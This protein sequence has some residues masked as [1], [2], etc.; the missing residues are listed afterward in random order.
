MSWS[1]VSELDQNGNI[2]AYE[3]QLEPLDFPANISVDLVNV[4][5]L[6]V[7]ATDLEEFVHYSIIVRAYTSVGPGPYSDPVTVRTAEDGNVHIFFTL[8]FWSLNIHFS[9][10]STSRTSSECPSRSHLLH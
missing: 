2:I 4:T 7:R 9:I 6:Q 10:L 1:E 8:C 5:S 3:V